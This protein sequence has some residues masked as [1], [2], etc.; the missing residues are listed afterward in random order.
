MGMGPGHWEGEEGRKALI[1][2]TSKLTDE[3]WAQPWHEVLKM[4]SYTGGGLDKTHDDAL[5]EFL[6]GRAA[7]Y[8][9]GS[10]EILELENG[11]D[12][13]FEIGAFSCFAMLL[14]IWILFSLLNLSFK[15]LSILI[16]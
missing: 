9:A 4:V 10:Y 5:A 8:A 13:A 2:G 6:E 1:D 7:V 16:P 14:S 11:V 3:E 12:G 15:I